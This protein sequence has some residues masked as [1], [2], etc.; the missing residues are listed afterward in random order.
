MELLE[1]WSVELKGLMGE[2]MGLESKAPQC[3]QH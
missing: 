2:L 1:L 3:A